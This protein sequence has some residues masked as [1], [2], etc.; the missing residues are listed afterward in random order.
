MRIP[1]LTRLKVLQI[2]KFYAPYKGGIET[3]LENLA[4]SLH[5]RY[6]VGV[7]VAN[8]GL[9]AARSTYEVRGGVAVE[10]LAT[11]FRFASAPICP[12]MIRRLRYAKVDIVHVHL[13]NP[14]GVLAYL[15]SGQ[16]AKLIVSYHSDTVRQRGLATLFEPLQQLF[17]RK[18]SAII[19][20][21][22]NYLTSSASLQ[23]HKS[24]CHVIPY[25]ISLS[26]PEEHYE[27]AVNIRRSFGS[28]VILA[29]GRLVYYKGFE[30]LVRAMQM[31]PREARL[32]IVGEGPDR[33]KLVALAER[34]DL[35]DRVVFCGSVQ[36]SLQP[37]YRAADIFVLPSVARSE[38]FGIV[39]IEAMA[40]GTPVINTQL[41]SGVPF[42][43]VHGETGLTVPPGDPVALA[44]AINRLLA[45]S[46]LRASLG[47]R[48]VNRAHSE[49]GVDK[50]INRIENLYEA[51]MATTAA[52]R[53]VART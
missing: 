33:S 46:A 26:T 19:V 40:A 27:E 2:G 52:A 41:D 37:Y 22:P 6:D 49:F 51:V 48:G 10:R 34:L 21:S 8:H 9:N 32:V 18:A 17:L 50:M 43:S 14:I 38:A 42:V 39:Q 28:S 12:G 7:L 24:R 5:D 4:T 31:V 30:Y 3:F 1:E 11:P 53:A 23:G 45:D 13:P 15:L 29:V 44:N 25:G 36:T 16:T 35:G 47:R 20:A